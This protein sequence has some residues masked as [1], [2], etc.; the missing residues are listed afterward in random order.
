[1][2]AARMS[3]IMVLCILA[4]LAIAITNIFD[5]ALAIIFPLAVFYVAKWIESMFEN[6]DV[7]AFSALAVILICI[8]WPAMIQAFLWC[9]IEPSAAHFWYKY[10]SIN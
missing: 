8:S 7:I 5:V 3:I 2:N 9:V 10:E 1:M 4:V 6:Y